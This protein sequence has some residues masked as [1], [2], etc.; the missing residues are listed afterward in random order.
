MRFEI[1]GTVYRFYSYVGNHIRPLGSQSVMD[2][3]LVGEGWAFM[4]VSFIPLPAIF[5]ILCM[6]AVLFASSTIH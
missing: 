1:E 3:G 2:V 4:R 6:L 5:S